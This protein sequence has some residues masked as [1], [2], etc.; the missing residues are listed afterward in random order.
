MDPRRKQIRLKHYDYSLAGAYFL[1]I[2]TEDRIHRFGEVIAGEMN[3]NAAGCLADTGLLQSAQATGFELD[4]G[5][6]MPNHVHCII[7]KPW[8]PGLELTKVTKSGTAEGSVGRY[9]QLYKS[10]ITAQYSQGVKADGWPPYEG[11]L[12]QRNYWEHV[13]RSDEA[14]DAIREYIANNPLQWHLDRENNARSGLSPF[15]EWIRSQGEI[16]V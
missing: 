4:S 5:I 11:R 3:L 7:Y 10:G 12:M 15:Y 9:V 14:L 6:V 13:I 2:C 1:T 8:T 16:P